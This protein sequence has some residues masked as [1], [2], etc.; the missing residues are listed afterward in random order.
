MMTE[1]GAIDLLK[2]ILPKKVSYA[3][4]ICASNCYGD[5]M[6]YQEPEPYAIEYGIKA[7]QENTKLKAEIEQLKHQIETRIKVVITIE[8]EYSEYVKNERDIYVE[9]RE[10]LDSNY[11]NPKITIV[12]DGW[13][14]I[15]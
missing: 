8:L 10:Y 9:L 12:K 7:I 14:P 2:G 4:M 13:E 1:Q 5:E 15:K 11:K 6:V 3:K